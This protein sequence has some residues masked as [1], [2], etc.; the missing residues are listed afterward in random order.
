M[1]QKVKDLLVA[2]GTNEPVQYEKL[3]NMWVTLSE[4]QVNVLLLRISRGAHVGSY[5]VKPKTITVNGVE[6]Q[7]PLTKAPNVGEYYYLVALLE[8]KHFYHFTWSDDESDNRALARGICH[9]TEEAA[10]AHAKALLL[11]TQTENL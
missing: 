9:S 11:P 4:T 6:I 5:R 2:I 10:V 8:S 3:P 7:A 1:D